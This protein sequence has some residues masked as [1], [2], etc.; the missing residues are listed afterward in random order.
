MLLA[1]NAD[2]NLKDKAGKT[3]LD[4]AVANGHQDVVDALQKS[5]AG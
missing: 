3:A 5:I 1:G 2:P 4:Y